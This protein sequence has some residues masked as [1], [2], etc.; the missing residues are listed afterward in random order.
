MATASKPPESLEDQLAAAERSLY[1]E[2]IEVARAN[3]RR[4][5]GMQ[6]SAEERM[7]LTKH[8]LDRAVHPLPGGLLCGSRVGDLHAASSQSS[9]L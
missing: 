7:V 6:G 9:V 8:M 5:S 1:L 3:I 4:I 2:S